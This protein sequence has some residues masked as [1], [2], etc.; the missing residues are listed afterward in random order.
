ML[1]HWSFTS[2][3]PLLITD[4]E[5]LLHYW[6]PS[7][8]SLFPMLDKGSLGKPVHTLPGLAALADFQDR[9]EHLCQI[10]TAEA[11]MIPLD[12][13]G[14]A[15]ILMPIRTVTKQDWVTISLV[16]GL[17]AELNV[18]QNIEQLL[19][20]LNQHRQRSGASSAALS[21]QMQQVIQ[22]DKLAAI[23]QLAAGVAHEINN[24]IGYICS[25]LNTL[26]EYID[27]LLILTD[28]LQSSDNLKELKQQFETLDYDF[29][30]AD[31]KDC[32]KESTEGANRVRDIIAA[33]KDF[34]HA[35]DGSF[36]ACSLQEVFASTLKLATNELK[37]KCTVHQN[38]ADIGPIDCNASQ[39]KQVVMNMIVNASHAI[40]ESGNIWLS[41][42]DKGSQVYFCIEDDGPGIPK[43]VQERIYEPFFTTKPAGQGTG[44]GLSLSYAI[45]QRHGGHIE[46]TDR[47]PHGTRFTIWL[48]KQQ[49]N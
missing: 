13:P 37:Y 33:L 45:V 31:I 43:E 39:I 48:P 26:T 25:N 21:Q 10:R 28:Q 3:L 34:S 17:S 46:L 49:P 22:A 36:N 32:I 15:A 4:N 35:D 14:Q 9:I 16:S 41:M 18:E 11:Q 30:K 27:K 42:G 44:L 6:T 5:G 23:G 12:E 20:V 24:P 29:I 19:P 38:Y 1:E 40:K 2:D 8:E 7:T 47:Q